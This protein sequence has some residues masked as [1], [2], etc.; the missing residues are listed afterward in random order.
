MH[1]SCEKEL[2]MQTNVLITW[3]NQIIMHI[4]LQK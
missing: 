2:C 1:M 3:V 4:I